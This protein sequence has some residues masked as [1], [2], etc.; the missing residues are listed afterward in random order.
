MKRLQFFLVFILICSIS[1]VLYRYTIN[2]EQ[3]KSKTS[4]IN[5]PTTIPP[6]IQDAKRIIKNTNVDNASID[7]LRTKA[8]AYYLTEDYVNAAKIYEQL[9]E[10]LPQD[11][12]LYQL[13]GDT[14]GKQKDY[15]KTQMMYEKSININP[16]RNP[17]I[18]A[19]ADL[20][21]DKLLK[22]NDAINVYIVALNSD[23]TNTQYM[24]L[25]ANLY[26]IQGNY[27]DALSWYEKVL[28]QEP[29]NNTAKIQ[30]EITKE[31]IRR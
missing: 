7:Q 22:P 3:K 18:S 6:V 24:L 28:L 20:F 5:T 11:S 14:Y 19:L 1:F 30:K 8:Y 12:T 9:I 26:K 15:K 29:S 13:L 21:Y 4:I 2:I 16:L 31:F 10:K 27:E 25:L 23:P 17:A